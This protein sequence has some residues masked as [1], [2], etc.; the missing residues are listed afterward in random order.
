[1]KIKKTFKALGIILLSFFLLLLVLPFFFKG[2]VETLVK[3]EI[4]KQIEA[5]VD[6]KSTSLSL[7]RNFP[8]LTFTI[9][10]LS[11]TGKDDF[12]TTELLHVGAL[13][14]RID[15][16]KIFKGNYELKEIVIN[17]PE[18][19]LLVLKNGKTNWDIM[20]SEVEN[21]SENTSENVNDY[22]S[23]TINIALKHFVIENANLSYNDQTSNFETV[24]NDLNTRISG[25]L[26]TEK[27]EIKAKITTNLKKMAIDGLS[28]ANN[29]SI[30]LDATILVD[31]KNYIFTFRK[32]QLL[33]NALAI[34]FDG[35]VGMLNDDIT[36]LLNF[37]TPN[38]EFKSLL[39]LIPSMYAADFNKIKTSGGF[40]LKGFLNGTYNE[41]SMPGY[42]VT[43]L[44]DNASFSHHDMPTSVDNIKINADINCKTGETDAIRINVE[45][46]DFSLAGNPFEMQLKLSHLISDPNFD[47]KASGTL[48]FEKLTQ[49]LLLENKDLLKGKMQLHA[50]IK[51]ILSDITNEKFDRVAASGSLILNDFVYNGIE[52][53][54]INIPMS[55]INIA[56]AYID[57]INTHILLGES[58][59]VL[60]GK[61]SNYLVYALSDNETIKGNLDLNASFI[62]A[63]Q[64]MKMFLSEEQQTEVATA[65]TTNENA[66]TES[67][68][69]PIEFPKNIDFTF[70]SH[71]DSLYYDTFKLYDVVAKLVYHNQK[72]TFNPLQAN[73]LEGSMTLKGAVDGSKKE[74]IGIALDF[75]LK[76]FDI[77][78]SYKAIGMLQKIAPIAERTHGT[79]SASFNMNGSLNKQ[80]DPIYETLNGGGTLSTSKITIEGGKMLENLAITLGNPDY[81]QLVADKLHLSFEFLNGKIYQK[82][83][84]M[85]LAG[86]KTI[87][88]GNVGFDQQMDY[89]MDFSIPYG[90]IGSSVQESIDKLSGSLS[91]VG[92]NLN[93]GTELNIRAK[94][95]G[96]ISDPKITI[97]YGNTLGDL[98]SE[99]ENKIQDAI[100]KQKEEVISKVK[101][102]AN[103]YIEEAEKSG[104]KLIK[105]AEQAA[106][107]LTTE[108]QKLVDK[109]V[110]EAREQAEKLVTEAA[111]KGV[112]AEKLAKES[113]NKLVSEAEKK[114]NKLISEANKSGQELIKKAQT[115]KTKLIEEARKKAE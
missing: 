96:E 82:P 1:M 34:E 49:V 72:L 83:F 23:E 84:E 101:E 63:T 75:D 66:A 112:I 9:K 58:N 14:L 108:A 81:K 110:Q 15:I 87:L 6:F 92:I 13:R 55:Q 94:I 40:S 59:F 105:E 12:E 85:K 27:S 39:S 100:Q 70:Q 67:A 37:Q 93:A 11:I 90:K 57:L 79:M 74:T 24:I 89:N 10:E 106:A 31:L 20:V 104:D 61:V 62:N 107:K 102:T 98:K 80:F 45:Q 64:L 5:T 3:N 76:D 42:G 38:N 69:S 73:L 109:G 44:V 111:K 46:F 21:I 56:P 54:A 35:S 33:L 95:V 88:S 103:K 4:N 8:D 2:K 77:P 26:S 71:I 25:N 113:G 16:W 18:I 60:G 32:N 50:G 19:N 51:G 22:E 48:D 53:A 52:K 68:E 78:E 47:F 29:I 30:D 36:F 86:T 41:T 114:G 115:E 97:D 99:I 28:Y 43:I 65:T 7:L 17:K 91:Q